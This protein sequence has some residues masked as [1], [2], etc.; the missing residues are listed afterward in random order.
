MATSI[1]AA[2]NAQYDGEV[3]QA[4]QLQEPQIL[5][6]CRKLSNVT[7]STVQV[8][9]LSEFTAGA[10]TRHADIAN[11]GGTHTMA[12]ITLANR[13]SQDTLDYFDEF[14][15]N[16]NYRQP[17][18]QGTSGAIAREID[19]MIITPL[20]AVDLSN[21]GGT[22]VSHEIAADIDGGSPVSNQ[23]FTFAK[24]TRAL[25]LLK[26]Q[27][28][29]GKKWMIYT[30]DALEYILNN[31]TELKN[32]DYTAN[33]IQGIMD[34]TIKE[35]LGFIWVCSTSV[36]DATANIRDLYAVNE[37]ALAFAHNTASLI[38]GEVVSAPE[39]DAVLV[40]AKT[41]SGAAVIDAAGVVRIKVDE[42]V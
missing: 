23:N 10:R 16:V 27:N 38:K 7:G 19:S 41:S 18:A 13:Y 11:T 30:P 4:F 26:N 5:Q 20:D 14:M 2:F 24:M 9:K 31:V 25:K 35:A 15:T 8:P 34:G 6:V 42:S 1:T 29:T 3:K 28:V 37:N 21:A 33:R 32:S 36:T 17:Y 22:G 39:K 40:R 12:T